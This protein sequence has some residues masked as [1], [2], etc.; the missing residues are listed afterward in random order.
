[1]NLLDLSKKYNT[2]KETGHNYISNFYE[3]FFSKYR[4]RSI[5]LIE[6]GVQFGE[7]IRLWNDYF[8]DVNI[9]GLDN[10]ERDFQEINNF[11]FICGDAY[12]EEIS[13]KISNADIIIDD[14]PHDY[15][16][17]IKFLILY[18]PKLNKD[19]IMV[20]EDIQK[21]YLSSA[22]GVFDDVV[23]LV[24]KNLNREYKINKVFPSG[25]DISVLQDSNLYCVERVT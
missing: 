22:M 19:G 8:V 17:Q 23:K 15:I 1:M 9:I 21:Q 24:S 12:D 20:I 6:I 2:D 3:R 4:G 14:G 16:S 7:S 5:T 11:K 25:Q 10:T 18:L 13:K